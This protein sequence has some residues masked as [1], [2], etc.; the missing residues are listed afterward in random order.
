MN[1]SG[2]LLREALPLPH[3]TPRARDIYVTRKHPLVVYFKRLQH[4]MLYFPPPTESEAPVVRIFGAGAAV[5]GAM[6]L[7]S[8]ALKE[9]PHLIMSHR[10]QLGVALSTD[11]VYGGSEEA[12]EAAE[13]GETY[14]GVS[15]QERKVSTIQ[16]DIFLR[17]PN[18]GKS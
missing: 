4:L 15:P 6:M 8:D 1:S 12:T 10:V 5:K 3:R 2:P 16:I 18:K 17:S 9:Y 13:M 14:L 11:L 7:F